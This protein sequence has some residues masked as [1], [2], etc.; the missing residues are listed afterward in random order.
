MKFSKEKR[1]KL[2]LVCV[3][4]LGLLASIYLFV[5]TE[6]KKA[7]AQLQA[8]TRTARQ[9]LE[10]A[11]RW[12]RMGDSIT[13]SLEANRASLRSREDQMAPLDRF[14]WFHDLLEDF[15]KDYQVRLEDI[16]RTPEIGPVGLFP[17]F[18]YQAATF[19]VRMSGTFHEF[20][21]FLADLENKFPLLRVQ[22]LDMDPQRARGG[23]V[24]Q[25]ESLDI[26][27]RVV[28]LIRPSESL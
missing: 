6:Q 10:K 22:N 25:N 27:M 26:R 12:V 7:L 2:V 19:G 21:T 4:G 9:N 17:E 15:L 3:L 23:G 11:D 13:D 16:T 18:P 24:R 14:K 28:T 8:Q 5:I 1:D 20:G